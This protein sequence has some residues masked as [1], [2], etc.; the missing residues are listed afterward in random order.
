MDRF[1]S[2][3]IRSHDSADTFMIRTLST[4][5]ASC[6]WFQ[7]LIFCY[8]EILYSLEIKFHIQFESVNDTENEI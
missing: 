2:M 7:P 3:K 1:Q 8:Q 4:Y 5:S 6:D